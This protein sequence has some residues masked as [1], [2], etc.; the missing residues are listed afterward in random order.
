MPT[1]EITPRADFVTLKQTADK[2]GKNYETIRR[3]RASGRLHAVKLG[4]EYLVP[5]SEIDRL[6]G[7]AS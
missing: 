7:R 4:G 2:L 6:L 5:L 1:N 3:W